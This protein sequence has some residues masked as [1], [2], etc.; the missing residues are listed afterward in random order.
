METGL[1]LLCTLTLLNRRFRLAQEQADSLRRQTHRHARTGFERGTTF[2]PLEC[3]ALA[4]SDK[5]MDYHLSVIDSASLRI[6]ALVDEGD[7]SR[8]D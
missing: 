7:M 5:L 8:T 4:A 6:R 2:R 3:L 1:K